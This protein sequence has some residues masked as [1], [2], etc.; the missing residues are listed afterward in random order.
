MLKAK[1]IGIFC[2]FSVQFLNDQMNGKITG[3]ILDH[4]DQSLEY[5]SITAINFNDSTFT[6]ISLEF[7][8]YSIKI[9]LRL[10]NMK[11]PRN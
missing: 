8:L 6:G 1:L 4:S 2:L 11:I 9:G 10:G 5:A 3:I 7:Y